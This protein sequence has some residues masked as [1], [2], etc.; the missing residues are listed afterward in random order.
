MGGTRTV[1]S[2]HSPRNSYRI[3]RLRKVAKTIGSALFCWASSVLTRLRRGQA[4]EYFMWVR[5]VRGALTATVEA[6]GREWRP[7]SAFKFNLDNVDSTAFNV[8]FDHNLSRLQ[9]ATF[10]TRH[11][12]YSC[13]VP[14]SLGFRG[15]N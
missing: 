7:A 12:H 15:R 11:H 3:M 14:Y 8:R 4:Y 6:A 1:L 9:D 10:E 5:P 13:G 2:C